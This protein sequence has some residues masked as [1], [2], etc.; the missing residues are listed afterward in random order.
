MLL[1]CPCRV[2][3]VQAFKDDP[4]VFKGNL[5]AQTANELLKVW[6]GF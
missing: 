4:L 5:R 3:Q 2:L 6:L 1:G